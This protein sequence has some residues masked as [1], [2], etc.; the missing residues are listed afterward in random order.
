MDLRE[1][2][3]RA[4]AERNGAEQRARELEAAHSRA[5]R[6]AEALQAELTAWTA[7]GPIVRAVRALLLRR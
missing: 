3:G 6:R 7:G 2:V 4:E 5:E 1:R